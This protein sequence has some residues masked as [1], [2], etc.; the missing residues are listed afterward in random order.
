MRLVVDSKAFIL[1]EQIC[2]GFYEKQKSGPQQRNSI[3]DQSKKYQR[4]ADLVAAI[5]F[6]LTLFAL[7]GGF[8][9]IFA[10]WVAWIHVPV[11]FWGA[12]AFLAAKTCPLTPLEKKLRK[13]AGAQVTE[14]GFVEGFMPFLKKWVESPRQREFLIGSLFLIWSVMVYFF[15]WKR[16]F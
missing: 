5:H 9:V 2:L 13:K 4:A 16:S 6:L 8:L 10:R 7:L 1:Y 3:M 15:L 11:A 12:Y 14:D